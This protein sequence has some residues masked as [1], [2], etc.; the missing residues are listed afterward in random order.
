MFPTAH[1]IIEDNLDAALQ[2]IDGLLSSGNRV[3]IVSKPSPICIERICDQC[4]PR[5]EHILFRFT[6][7]ARDDDILSFWEPGAPP[8]RERT[9]ALELAFE[10]GFATSVSVEPMLDIRDIGELVA[11]LSPI[12]THSIWIGMMNK[13][14][15]RVRITCD[16]T[17]AEVARIRSEQTDERIRELFESLRDNPLIR[18]KESIKRVVGIELLSESGLDR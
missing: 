17:A 10:K 8:Y 1:D 2:V 12:V 14:D 18:W 7:T 11:E 3:L 6:I 9:E 4:S 13:I 16:K 15:E 5:R